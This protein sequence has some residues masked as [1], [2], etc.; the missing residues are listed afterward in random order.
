MASSEMGSVTSVKLLNVI[1]MS[2]PLLQVSRW[3][4]KEELRVPGVPPA[5]QQNAG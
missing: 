1:N 3:S 5:P 2:P 4:P